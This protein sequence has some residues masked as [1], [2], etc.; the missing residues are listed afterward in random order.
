MKVNTKLMWL[1]GAF[2]LPAPVSGCPEGFYTGSI[3]QDTY[4][5]V[6]DN[7]AAYKIEQRL[8]VKYFDG[9]VETNFC[10]NSMMNL[11]N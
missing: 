1:S 9:R 2:A 10:V 4:N 11:K 5:L 3:T 6:R 7:S 8:N